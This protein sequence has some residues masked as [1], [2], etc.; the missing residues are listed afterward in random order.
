MEDAARESLPNG[1]I[2]LAQ[3]HRARAGSVG[4]GSGPSLD[5]K[6]NFALM[7]RG[8][9]A[10]LDQSA[11]RR[12]IIASATHAF[13]RRVRRQQSGTSEVARKPVIMWTSR[14]RR[15]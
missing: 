9:K 15:D 2:L 8:V 5:A 11:T 12:F 14:N 3:R 6:M 4:D 10:L 7:R 1:R 13:S